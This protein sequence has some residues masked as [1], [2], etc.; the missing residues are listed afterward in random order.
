M[1]FNR[2][3]ALTLT[4]VLF[5]FAIASSWVVVALF[6]GAPI[7]R[8]RRPTS[9]GQQSPDSR[10]SVGTSK[11][12]KVAF[13][14]A[15]GIALAAM[16][17]SFNDAAVSMP[18]LLI[19]LGLPLAFRLVPRNWL[20]GMRSPRTLLTTEETWYRQ[21]VITGVAFV[22]VGTIWLAVLAVKTAVSN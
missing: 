7:W 4:L 13:W 10:S 14:L 6:E 5:A 2:L 12:L 8:S 15:Y 22:A 18:L 11:Y 21:N 9:A 1:D 20:Y 19:A 17:A 16:A 3:T